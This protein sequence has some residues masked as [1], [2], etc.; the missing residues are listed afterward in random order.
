MKEVQISVP[1]AYPL[2][3]LARFIEQLCRKEELTLTMKGTLAKYPGCMHWHYR[4]VT[5]TGTLEITLWK[6]PQQLWFSVQSGRT[7]SWIEGSIARLK[8]ALE[9]ELAKK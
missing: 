6:Q 3:R 8:S 4:K 7:G 5:A 1:S 2:G 9:K